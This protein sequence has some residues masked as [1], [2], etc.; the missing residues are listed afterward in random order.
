MLRF[1]DYILG[2][3]LPEQKPASGAVGEFGLPPDAPESILGSPGRKEMLTAIRERLSDL[4]PNEK[5][6]LVDRMV[7]RFALTVANL[8]ASA[9]HH[10]F[11]PWGLLNHSM[12]VAVRSV[13]AA[14]EMRFSEAKAA[15][16]GRE[17]ELLPRWKYAAFIF[18]LLH[19]IGKVAQLRVQ[20]AEG[21]VWNPFV[22]SLAG[23]YVRKSLWPPEDR[24]AVVT[25]VPKRAL[26]AHEEYNSLFV[27][28]IL[29]PEAAAYLGPV[30]P[31]ALVQRDGRECLSGA[32]SLYEGQREHRA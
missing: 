11:G 26:E 5:T 32:V 21:A 7:S 17:Y 29:T 16:P 12:D 14:G 18:G 1:L 9:D 25:W 23:F 6:E 24:L 8:P 10:H 2:A 22:E 15:D 28:R 13:T 20:T 31:L 3:P 4:S 30:L 19:D 27:G